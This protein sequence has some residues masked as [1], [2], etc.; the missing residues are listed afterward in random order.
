MINDLHRHLW[1]LYAV[2]YLVPISGTCSGISSKN[3][4]RQPVSGTSPNLLEISLTDEDSEDRA[5]STQ[6]SLVP[7]PES[8]D[9]EMDAP[10]SVSSADDEQAGSPTEEKEQ[11]TADVTVVPIAS[12]SEEEQEEE[13]GEEEDLD[14]G[15]WDMIHLP[16]KR[17]EQSPKRLQQ[18]MQSAVLVT[19]H[20]QAHQKSSKCWVRA[21]HQCPRQSLMI[22]SIALRSAAMSPAQARHGKAVTVV[23][24]LL[25]PLS[26]TQAMCYLRRWEG[27]VDGS[28]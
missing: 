9:M 13:E 26:P 11:S 16:Q 25:L 22:L 5:D 15:R 2:I 14:E 4:L 7:S 20:D 19:I 24:V 27:G 17:M 3:L 8:T 10:I 6:P 18:P 21:R 28:K 12:E 23:T 1:A